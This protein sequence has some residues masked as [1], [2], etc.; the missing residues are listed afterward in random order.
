M[1]N[2]GVH[3]LFW[4]LQVLTDQVKKYSKTRN[5][6]IKEQQDDSLLHTY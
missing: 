5:A 2:H 6:R 1:M 3:L 4:Y